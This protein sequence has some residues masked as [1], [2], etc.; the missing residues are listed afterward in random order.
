MI[1]NGQPYSL[2]LKAHSDIYSQSQINTL[3]TG[4]SAISIFSALVCSFWAD[5]TGV[6]WIPSLTVALCVM[7]GS[8]CMAIWNIPIRLK[9]FSFYICGVGNALNPLFMSWA[10]ETVSSIFL[11]KKAVS[12]MKFMRRQLAR[13]RSELLLLQA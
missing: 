13:R 10:S 8:I 12:L 6:R 1:T 4:Q 11:H 9:L 2:Y 3:P 7:F 5:A